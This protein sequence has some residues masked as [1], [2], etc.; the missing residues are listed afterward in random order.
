MTA[1]GGCSQNC[2]NTLGSYACSC[3]DGYVIANG[4]MCNDVNECMTANGGC[5]QNCTNTF[6]S[7]A[8]SCLAGYTISPSNTSNCDLTIGATAS[9]RILNLTE[10]E[11]TILVLAIIAIVLILLVVL[12]LILLFIYFKIRSR[13]LQPE[14]ELKPTIAEL[15][16]MKKEETIKNPMLHQEVVLLD[17]KNVDEVAASESLA[18]KDVTE[19]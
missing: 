14:P 1:N 4:T 19:P 17:T 13:I 2:T 10:T 12:I 8:C 18:P 7:Y 6:G 9:P 11:F 16:K 3:S 15:E 5:S